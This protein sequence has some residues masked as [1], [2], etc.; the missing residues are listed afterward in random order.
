MHFVHNSEWQIK[1]FLISSFNWDDLKK[2]K[3]INKNIKVGVLVDQFSSINESIYY[4]KKI[5]ADA[6]HPHYKLLNEKKI[7]KIKKNG[8]KVYT[9]TVNEKKYIDLMKKYKVDGIISGYPDKI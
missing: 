8:F 1:D 2:F 4:G 3:S 9:W 7:K 5:N 6:I